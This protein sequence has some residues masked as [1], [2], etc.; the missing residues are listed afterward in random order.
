MNGA[1]SQLDIC[2]SHGS[3]FTPPTGDEKLGIALSSLHL[4][5]LNALRHRPENGTCGWYIW[6]GDVLS[7]DPHFFEPLHVQH[8]AS[9]APEL[10][11]FLALAPG[12]RVLLAPELCDIW[13]DPSLLEQ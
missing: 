6:G 2:K 10:V 3:A 13:H 9:H 8:L 5:P 4:R 11:P 1:T 12:W 7:Q